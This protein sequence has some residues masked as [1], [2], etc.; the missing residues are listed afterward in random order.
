[1]AAADEPLSSPRAACAATH[2]VADAEERWRREWSSALESLAHDGRDSDARREWLNVCADKGV[3]PHYPCDFFVSQG[4]CTF[5]IPHEHVLRSGSLIDAPLERDW[6]DGPRSVCFLNAGQCLGS[7]RAHA[8]EEHRCFDGK[9]WASGEGV[10]T[11]GWTPW[12][13]LRGDEH[14]ELLPRE[15]HPVEWT[16]PKVIKA[17]R[18][19]A[20]KPSLPTVTHLTDEPCGP[21]DYV[22]HPGDEADAPPGDGSERAR[23]LA[24]A[25]HSTADV[26]AKYMGYEALFCDDSNAFIRF[27]MGI[28]FDPVTNKIDVVREEEDAAKF[29]AQRKRFDRCLRN[30]YWIFPERVAHFAGPK[31]E[32]YPYGAE[33]R[34]GLALE[35]LRVPYTGTVVRGEG[36]LERVECED[37]KG[38]EFE[39]FLAPQPF[40][41]AGLLTNKSN[42]TNDELASA[43]VDAFASGY[44]YTQRGYL[45]GPRTV[46]QIQHYID[47]YKLQDR[48]PVFA[49]L[50]F[51]RRRTQLSLR[52]MR[53]IARDRLGPPPPFGHAKDAG[54]SSMWISRQWIRA[55]AALPFE[56]PWIS[57]CCWECPEG[58]RDLTTLCS[59]PPKGRFVLEVCQKN[60]PIDRN[61]YP[62]R[63]VDDLLRGSAPAPDAHRARHKALCTIMGRDYVAKPAPKTPP[64]RHGRRKRSA[65]ES[66]P[67]ASGDELAELVEERKRRKQLE[68]E[69]AKAKER[70]ASLEARVASALV[71]LGAGMKVMQTAAAANKR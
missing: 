69:L 25:G 8:G 46:G 10:K 15:A 71:G 5:S 54:E 38:S 34:E 29:A 44:H 56:P 19:D 48:H 53:A 3:R 28:A 18:R 13:E 37:V 24:T 51:E 68:E 50:H 52:A 21:D 63:S 23:R 65:P 57:A 12:A 49:N 39:G 42:K 32:A 59:D 36:D 17:P 7:A 55:R 22:L 47:H 4:D 1:M 16:A 40:I 6:K 9:P 11:H 64:D 43:D 66:P 33:P 62:W 41:L 27:F 61:D 14:I 35:P 2:F 60:L 67:Q 20:K 26:L 45:I 31:G 58:R 30:V 70:I